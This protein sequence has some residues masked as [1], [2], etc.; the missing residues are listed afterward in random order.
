[1]STEHKTKFKYSHKCHNPLCGIEYG[2]NSKASKTCSDKCRQA[3]SRSKK[4][5]QDTKRLYRFETSPFAHF[6]A[7]QCIRATTVQVVPQSL[8]LL[9][10]LHH[11]SKL[12]RKADGYGSTERYALCHLYPVRGKHAVGTLHPKNLVVSDRAL[13]AEHKNSL[14][15]QGIGD[16]I[17]RCN[18]EPRWQVH[19]DASVKSTITKLVQYLGQDFCQLVAVKLS[20]QPETRTQYLDKLTSHMRHPIMLAAIEAAG[21]LEKVKTKHLSQILVAITG[22]STGGFHADDWGMNVG[23]VFLAESQRL[24]KYYPHLAE[25]HDKFLPLHTQLIE[26]GTYNSAHYVDLAT[27]DD[28]AKVNL[29]SR[30]TFDLFHGATSLEA[31]CHAVGMEV[32]HSLKRIHRRRLRRHSPHCTSPMSISLRHVMRDSLS[33]SLRKNICPLKTFT[34]LASAS[35][36]PWNNNR[37]GTP[38]IKRQPR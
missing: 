36:Q 26:S 11:V 7:K 13:N 14:P 15:A 8:E 34:L 38:L 19:P 1:M 23:E 5:S 32:S 33:P 6:L 25:A 17:L 3:F 31:Y 16:S 21:S 9:R 2:T 12:T 20:L 24:S 10:E 35:F 22:K 27:P 37:R 4:Q 18:L 28:L 29:V 30:L